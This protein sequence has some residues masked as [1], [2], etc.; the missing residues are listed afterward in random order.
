MNDLLLLKHELLLTA[1]LLLF[2]LIKLGKEISNSRFIKTTYVL[3]LLNFI[4]GFISNQS[5][6]LFG[7]MF[8]TDEFV[9][10]QKNILNLSV[11]LIAFSSYRWMEPHRHLPEYFIL[12]TASLLGM[13]FMISSGNLLMFYLGLELSAIPLAALCN[14]DLDKKSSSEAGMKMILSSAFASGILLMGI[15]LLY[16]TCG[17][18]SFSELSYAIYGNPLQVFAF[19]LLFAGFAFKLSIVP[20]HLWTADVYEGSPVSVTAF[21]S[22]VSKG[23]MVFAFTSVLYRV[24]PNMEEPVYHTLFITAVATMTIGNLFAVRQQNLKRFLAFSSIAQVGFILVGISGFS[25][26][27]VAAAVYF[28]LVYAFS[29]LAAFAV[30]GLI[31]SGTGKE[32]INDYRGLVNTNPLLAWTLTIAFFS[33]AGIPPAAG[34]FGKFFLLAAG[35]GK[36]NFVLISIAALNMIVSLYYYLRVVRAMFMDKNETPLPVVARDGY[37]NIVLIVCLAGITLAGLW[38]LPYNF[39]RQLSGF[40]YSSF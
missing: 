27:G 40:V 18:L 19:I 26:E 16:G 7:N 29:N 20:F 17:T 9:L 5:G 38:N 24:F 33:L 6:S 25:P 34:F 15:S 23:A 11:V 30:I 4:A 39:V 35:A 2:I 36:G 8:F 14:F 10:L 28:I 22:V 32:N 13:F 3:L 12:L 21:L 37:F 31:T 1:L